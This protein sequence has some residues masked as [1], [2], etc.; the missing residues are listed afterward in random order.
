MSIYTTNN[1]APSLMNPKSF[2]PGVG[3]VEWQQ[4]TIHG[5]DPLGILYGD[6]VAKAPFHPSSSSALWTSAASTPVKR[7]NDAED[8]AS[9]AILP[10]NWTV[11]GEDSPIIKDWKLDGSPTTP[12]GTKSPGLPSLSLLDRP[13]Q[14]QGL[15]LVSPSSSIRGPGESS[16]VDIMSV[17]SR[18]HTEKDRPPG[19]SVI[20]I[21]R[22]VTPDGKYSSGRR[23]F[24]RGEGVSWT[25]DL[26]KYSGK[27]KGKGVAK[28]RK[29]KG[30]V[31]SV[32]RVS[33]ISEMVDGEGRER[34]V[35]RVGGDGVS[36]GSGSRNGN[37]SMS[38]LGGSHY[39]L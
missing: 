23:V 14:G 12:T 28:W 18:T 2:I 8:D 11:L 31:G 4:P 15:R 38:S 35:E 5:H 24:S 17:Y 37:G 30:A 16:D 25:A 19:S 26:G 3:P 1:D 22:D 39:Y 7:R 36:L 13:G 9:S 27:G 20:S 32:S 29:G 21:P 10:P 33:I 34:G 6:L